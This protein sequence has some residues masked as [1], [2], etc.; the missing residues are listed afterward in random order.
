MATLSAEDVF[1][2][3]VRGMLAWL[4]ANLGRDMDVQREIKS[5]SYSSKFMHWVQREFDVIHHRGVQ[6]NTPETWIAILKVV[7]ASVHDLGSRPGERLAIVHVGNFDV[8]RFAPVRQR[9][10]HDDKGVLNVELVC[11]P[12]AGA[13][14]CIDTIF[15]TN[16][17]SETQW[18]N[19]K[20]YTGERS[21]L[22]D[23]YDGPHLEQVDDMGQNF[24][25]IIHLQAPPTPWSLTQRSLTQRSS[26]Q[27]SS[28]KTLDPVQWSDHCTF[29]DRNDQPVLVVH[30][31]SRDA[32]HSPRAQSVVA[33]DYPAR[34]PGGG[35]RGQASPHALAHPTCARCA[36]AWRHPG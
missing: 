9:S 32:A 24:N 12:G 1:L 19:K 7:G 23:D 21:A 28:T 16:I 25:Q 2:A 18:L 34:V 11:D 17:G 10:Y 3:D 20:C 6:R 30:R 22:G 4:R 5:Q 13:C 14:G 26:T 27:R 29:F 31:L 33:G 15:L 8:T 35:G 36:M